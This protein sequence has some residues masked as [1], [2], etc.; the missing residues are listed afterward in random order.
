MEQLLV[1]VQNL[2]IGHFYVF[3]CALSR[4][5]LF[6]YLSLRPNLHDLKGSEFS[7]QISNVILGMVCSLSF[8]I[9][10]K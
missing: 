6:Q 8:A 10:S 2:S 1:T 7:F 4:I 3:Y 5:L 9:H